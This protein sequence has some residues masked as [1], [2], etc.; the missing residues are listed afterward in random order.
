MT[1]NFTI[2]SL[3]KGKSFTIDKALWQQFREGSEAALTI[4]YDQLAPALYNYGCHLCNDHALI[5][6]V[7]Q[8]L[9]LHLWNKRPELPEVTYIKSYLIT[10][11]RRRIIDSLKK[12]GLASMED[13]AGQMD[14]EIQL[15]TEQEWILSDEKEEL[16]QRVQSLL[17]GLTKRQK[18]AIFLKFYQG[19]SNNEV[20][21]IMAISVPAVY[22]IMFK[23]ILILRTKLLHS[24]EGH[25]IIIILLLA[26]K[27]PDRHLSITPATIVHP[28]ALSL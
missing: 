22:N 27:A 14:F 3:L 6:D 18:E 7:I 11:F 24:A 16:A 17:N 5:Q 23:A 10:A 21:E 25:T 19:V 26:S 8:D 12:Q 20:A 2:G 4:I 13:I 15:S 1:S 9:F 28:A